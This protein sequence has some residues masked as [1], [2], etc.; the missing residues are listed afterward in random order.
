M[1]AEDTII[2]LHED[3]FGV[4]R[5]QRMTVD[6]GKEQEISMVGL[7]W[8]ERGIGGYPFMFSKQKGGVVAVWSISVFI[9]RWVSGTAAVARGSCSNRP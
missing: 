1:F 8:T 9:V 7:L 5:K 6:D 3:I 4:R 2:S